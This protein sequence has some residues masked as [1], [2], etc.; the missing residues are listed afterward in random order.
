M[1]AFYKGDMLDAVN[2]LIDASEKSMSPLL[3]IVLDPY[4]YE[5]FLTDR[6]GQD[7]IPWLEQPDKQ[8]EYRNVM[9]IRSEEGS[10]T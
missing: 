9:I 6:A 2:E 3:F 4:E 7:D 5:A 8:I 10:H 1:R